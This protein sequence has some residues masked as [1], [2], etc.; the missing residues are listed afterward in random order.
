MLLFLHALSPAAEVHESVYRYSCINGLEFT[1]HYR[2]EEVMLVLPDQNLTLSLTHT[3]T[4]NTYTDKET[5]FWFDGSDATLLQRGRLTT[6]CDTDSLVVPP[7]PEPQDEVAAPAPVTEKAKTVPPA[8]SERTEPRATETDTVLSAQAADTLNGTAASSVAAAEAHL[9]EAHTD[10]VQRAE[11]SAF[12]VEQSDLQEKG[13][14][15]SP[16]TE[17]IEAVEPEPAEQT[18]TAQPLYTPAAAVSA[19]EALGGGAAANAT[20]AMPNDAAEENETVLPEQKAFR[21]KKEKKPVPAVKAAP[22]PA[23][24]FKGGSVRPKWEL[25]IKDGAI[26]L[27]ADFILSPI[28]F[29]PASVERVQLK[30]KLLYTAVNAEHTLKLTMLLWPCRIRPGGE[31]HNMTLFMQLDDQPKLQGCGHYVH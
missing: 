23:Y 2:V 10:T 29:A 21:L 8:E 5:T 25:L 11:S 24:T 27:S 12:A 6:F 7:A 3:N 28:T 18:A 26:T 22:E 4:G 17:E 16:F 20:E 9:S 15:V 19:T 1:A 30:H 31:V 14:A 13:I